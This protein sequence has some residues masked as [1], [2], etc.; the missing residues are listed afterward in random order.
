MHY[1]NFA[2]NILSNEPIMFWHYKEFN[3]NEISRITL[4]RIGYFEYEVKVKIVDVE[5]TGK[6]LNETIYHTNG[7]TNF[8]RFIK[9]NEFGKPLKE[10]I[11]DNKKRIKYED[12]F[13]YSSPDNYEI[14]S[15]RRNDEGKYDNSKTIFTKTGNVENKQV[16][17][18]DVI[19]E[20]DITKYNDFGKIDEH[21][22]EI[23]HIDGYIFERELNEYEN[24]ILRKQLRYTKDN[25]DGNEY[26]VFEHVYD[27]QGREIFVNAFDQ[28]GK[29]EILSKAEYSKDNRNVLIYKMGSET[30]IEKHFDNGLLT[31]YRSDVSTEEDGSKL[32]SEAFYKYNSAGMLCEYYETLY[33]DEKVK[34]YFKQIYEYYDNGLLKSVKYYGLNDELKFED[35]Y[36]I[37][38]AK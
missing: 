20:T 4:S 31:Y 3:S 25:V 33:V 23:F 8:T 13:K 5:F 29:K 1:P 11:R 32:Y 16:F 9:K 21:I 38:F 17:V 10:V 15:K 7:K 28:A 18:N 6:L 27:E 2:I 30:P 14:F 26:L 22:F 12:I 37:G 36:E 24:Q 35:V 19:Y 34:D